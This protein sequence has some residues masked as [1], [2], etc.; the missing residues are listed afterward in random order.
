MKILGVIPARYQSSRFPGKPLA[1]IFGKPMIWWVYQR[2]KMV[3]RL[4]DVIVATDD[5]RIIDSCSFFGI[6]AILTSGKH[7][8]GSERLSEVASKMVA[9]VYVTIQGD[10]PLLEKNTIN[11]VVDVLLSEN[12]I[13]CATLKTAY[14]N[15]VDVI[16]GTTPKVVTDLNND[17]LL[18]TRSAVPY[19]KA[20]LDYVIYKPI[21]VYAFRRDTLLEYGKLEMGPLEKAEEIELLRLVEHG[22]KIRIAEVASETVAVD[23]YKDL[24]RV[25]A[26][27]EEHPEYQKV[28]GNHVQ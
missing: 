12:Y 9:D 17:I 6:P 23:T 5:K 1:D 15:P 26:Y 20:A 7:R 24:E 3:D 28:G 18:F 11:K 4:T 16:N 2:A 13:P 27:I 21:G 19:P 22:Y 10:E 25:R 8:N 14:H